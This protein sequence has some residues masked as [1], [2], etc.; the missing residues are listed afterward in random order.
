[1]PVACGRGRCQ[2][3]D[4]N[5]RKG[6][7]GGRRLAPQMIILPLLRALSLDGSGEGMLHA[8]ISEGAVG[9]LAVLSEHGLKHADSRCRPVKRR[10][11]SFAS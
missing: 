2:R 11:R 6:N 8:G 7:H 1:M 4:S 10:R 3:V 5:S 9:K